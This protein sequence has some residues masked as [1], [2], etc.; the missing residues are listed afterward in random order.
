MDVEK[1][2]SLI[3][4]K[5]LARDLAVGKAMDLIKETA[6]AGETKPKKTSKAKKDAK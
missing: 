1:V 3:D 2:K 6:V 4:S 5:D